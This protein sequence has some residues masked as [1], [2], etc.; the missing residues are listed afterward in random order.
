[1]PILILTVLPLLDSFYSGFP[2]PPEI[3]FNLDVTTAGNCIPNITL[4]AFGIDLFDTIGWYYNDGNG[5]V[6]LGETS[7]SFKASLEYI[8]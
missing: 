5:F 8:N 4:E 2:S 3:D 7:S 1:M 6:G